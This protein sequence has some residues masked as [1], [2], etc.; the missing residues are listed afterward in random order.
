MGP[1][2]H[3]WVC[4][5]LGPFMTLRSWKTPDSGGSG[6]EQLGLTPRS[7]RHVHRQQEKSCSSPGPE[8]PTLI[9][10]QLQ[11]LSL[12]PQHPQDEEQDGDR[13]GVCHP[14]SPSTVPG[15]ETS[16]L[17]IKSKLLFPLCWVEFHL[18]IVFVVQRFG[19]QPFRPESLVQNGH[20]SVQRAV[21]RDTAPSTV[22]WS[23]SSTA[24]PSHENLPPP[25]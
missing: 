6:A 10:K 9:R 17:L 21:C 7:T 14:Q 12:C 23:Y 13:G 22:I 25:R 19:I 15:E 2:E 18:L 11:E 3:P 5:F 16:N 4:A 24:K 20:T 8:D 1:L